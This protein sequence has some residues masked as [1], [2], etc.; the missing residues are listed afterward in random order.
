MQR[1][2]ADGLLAVGCP[3]DTAAR[4]TSEIRVEWTGDSWPGIADGEWMLVLRG[5]GAGIGTG[6]DA[7]EWSTAAEHVAR[8]LAADNAQA[9]DRHHRG[10]R[11]GSRCGPSRFGRLDGKAAGQAEVQTG[12]LAWAAMC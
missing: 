10:S 11:T 1:S 3:A 4:L 9:N 8:N 12:G 5:H 7:S 2:V 6:I